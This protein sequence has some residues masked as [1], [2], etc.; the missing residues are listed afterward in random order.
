MKRVPVAGKFCHT[1]ESDHSE[2]ASKD[3]DEK[4][5]QLEEQC[6]R[7]R[8]LSDVL[9]K[10]QN[11]GDSGIQYTDIIPYGLRILNSTERIIT[12][13]PALVIKAPILELLEP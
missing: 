6:A 4:E 5:Q 2:S 8:D 3:L 11:A 10:Q 12:A 7:V 9:S 13:T 1:A